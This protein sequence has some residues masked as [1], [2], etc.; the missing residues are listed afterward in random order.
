VPLEAHVFAL[1]SKFMRASAERFS[2][3]DHV[4]CWVNDGRY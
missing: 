2:V 4:R 1:E 3:E